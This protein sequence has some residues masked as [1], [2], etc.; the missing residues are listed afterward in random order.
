EAWPTGG[1]GI[2]RQLKNE[3]SDCP[4]I[5]LLVARQADR[6]LASW[7]QADAVIAHPADPIATARTVAD[8]LRARLLRTRPATQ[9]GTITQLSA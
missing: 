6:W 5:C 1:M 2:S 9:L 4:P 3:I 7:S 8:L